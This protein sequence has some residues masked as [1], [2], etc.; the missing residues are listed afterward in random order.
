MTFRL[1]FSIV[2]LLFLAVPARADVADAAR[3]FDEGNAHYAVGNYD[4]AITAYR[5]AIEAGYASAP[6][7]Y[8]LGN[9]YYRLD[10]LGEAILSYERARRFQREDAET[11][12]NL[13]IARDRTEDSFS[14]LPTPV[15]QQLWESVV[16]RVGAWPLFAAGIVLWLLGGTL[17]VQYILTEPQ[18]AW[19]MRSLYVTLPLA[20]VL[21][22]GAFAAS[23]EAGVRQQAV[24]LAGEVSLRTVPSDTAD[25]AVEVHE[26]LLVDVLAAQQGWLELRLPNGMRGWAPSD[27][28]GSIEL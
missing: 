17:L 12:H 8:N 9:A 11:V 13:S 21:L 28:A 19:V 24:V 14:R 3:A 10:R 4:G 26:G 7:F 5:S 16:R 25:V 27:A 15:W 23:V 6:L 2:S 22:L 18:K 20:S 1:V